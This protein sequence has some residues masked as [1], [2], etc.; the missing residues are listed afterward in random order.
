MRIMDKLEKVEKIREKT[1]VSYADALEAL[2][3]CKGDILDAI[4]Y[5]ERSGKIDNG[6]TARF[7]SADSENKGSERL[8][9]ATAE[10]DRSTEN[11]TVGDGV[12]SFF[13]WCKKI[14]RKSIDT[15]FTVNKRDKEVIQVP[16]LVLVIA[17]IFGFWVVV[18]LMVIG[19]FFDFRYHF[20]GVDKVTVDVNGFCDR[21]AEGA[22]NMRHGSSKAAENG[23]N[24]A[25]ENTSENTDKDEA[26]ENGSEVTE[27]TSAED[28]VID[29]DYK[30]VGESDEGTE[31]GEYSDR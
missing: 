12:D 7:S 17:L 1:G 14:F 30:T 2:D 4:V 13:E 28:K 31:T 11:T 15:K 18:P 26:N 9:N 22:S 21:A 23:S 5:L 29:I 16:V 8:A 25:E 24:R 6:K 19:L 27:E 10:Y 3:I 20:D